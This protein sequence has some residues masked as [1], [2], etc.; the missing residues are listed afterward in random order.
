MTQGIGDSPSNGVNSRYTQW[1]SIPIKDLPLKN[2]YSIEKS[3]NYIPKW[4]KMAI[5]PSKVK[6]TFKNGTLSVE[7]TR[8]KNWSAWTSFLPKKK[9]R[10]LTNS[11]KISIDPSIT[12]VKRIDFQFNDNKRTKKIIGSGS[13]SNFKTSYETKL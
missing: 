13:C 9:W 12:K 4:E 11:I 2:G 3:T 7:E 1:I 5:N 6:I 8:T 10:M